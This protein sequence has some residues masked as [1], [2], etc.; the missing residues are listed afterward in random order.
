MGGGEGP[1][2]FEEKHKKILSKSQK[3]VFKKLCNAEH[4]K[5]F[6]EKQW[7]REKIDVHF[8]AESTLKVYV[9]F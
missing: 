2:H 7:L 8:E 9:L 6:S 3:L 1:C 4:F 5:I